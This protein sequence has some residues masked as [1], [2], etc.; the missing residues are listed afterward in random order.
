MSAI[1]Q[2]DNQT[3]SF[4][5]GLSSIANLNDYQQRAVTFCQDYL[6][7]KTE[8]LISTSGSTGIPKTIAIRRSQM[9]TS[10]SSTI[11]ALDLKEGIRGL[12]CI[13]TDYVGGKMM[14][15]RGMEL[16]MHM[17]MQA[18]SGDVSCVKNIDFT[19]LVPLQV[20]R[21]LASEPGRTF[22]KDCT[23]VIIGG[24]PIDTELAEQLN[25]YDNAIFQTFGMTETVSHIALKRLSNPSAKA[26][27]LLPDVHISQDDRGCLILEGPM[28]G[29]E[30]VQTNDL[31]EIIDDQHFKWLGRWDRVINSG[32]YKLNPEAIEAETTKALNGLGL[33]CECRLC[34]Q[35]HKE[36]GQMGVLVLELSTITPEI[37]QALLDHLRT[38]L[39]PYEVPKS[40]IGVHVFPRTE[41]GKVDQNK[42]LKLL[43]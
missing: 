10:A 24:A 7:G 18:P 23:T 9:Q 25:T 42:L 20:K 4:D 30:K 32:G 5:S 35:D 29:L 13:N 34:G 39:H 16:G 40:I 38:T 28:A 6:A 3:V 2:F 21:L 12:V 41:N 8:F 31:V 26:Y 19:A 11:K 15:V 27:E 1:L 33:T 43:K 36:L 17:I 14:L 37:R 22:L